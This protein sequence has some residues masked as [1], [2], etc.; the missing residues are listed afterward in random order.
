MSTHHMMKRRTKR[1]NGSRKRKKGISYTE[2]ITIPCMLIKTF[3]GKEDT[4]P[5]VL[6]GYKASLHFGVDEDKKNIILRVTTK[7]RNHLE[8]IIIKLIERYNKIAAITNNIMDSF[9]KEDS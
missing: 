4:L 7:H 2:S 5:A 6:K 1:K 3:I 8:D 9:Q